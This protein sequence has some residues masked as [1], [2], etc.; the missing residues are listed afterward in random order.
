MF[1]YPS[2]QSLL[3]LM[4]PEPGDFDFH[5]PNVKNVA[6]KNGSVSDEE[7]PDFVESSGLLSNPGVGSAGRWKLEINGLF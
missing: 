2:E 7:G 3:D 1:E 5:D 6:V 4:P